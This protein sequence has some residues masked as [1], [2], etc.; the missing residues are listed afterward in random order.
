MHDSEATHLTITVTPLPDAAERTYRS[1]AQ[2]NA[3]QPG[4]ER[5]S[6]RAPQQAAALR[7]ESPVLG[8]RHSRFVAPFSGAALTLIMRVLNQ[9]Q[10]RENPRTC[11]SSQEQRQLAALGLWH[12]DGHIHPA[13]SQRIG[14][15]LYQALTADPPGAQALHT[16]RDYATAQGTPLALNLRLP[17]DSPQLAVLPW[18]LLCDEGAVPL[19]LSRGRVA[20]CTR[21]LDMA[22]A[23]PLPPAH[24]TPLRILALAPHADMPAHH[25]HTEQQARYAAW[26]PLLNSG[27]VC[28]EEVSPVTRAALVDRMQHHPLPDIIH[29]YGHGRYQQGEGALLLDAP[30]G[31]PCWTGASTLAALFGGVRMVA[32]FACQGATVTQPASLFSG[33]A[34]ALCAAGIPLVL[35]M[36]FMVRVRAAVR[37]SGVM[38]RALAAGWSVQRAVSLVR[39]ALYVEEPDR[40][41]WYVPVLYV[42]SHN[43]APVAL[44]A[45]HTGA[46]A[47]TTATP[48]AQ[49]SSQRISARHNSQVHGICMRGSTATDQQ[50]SAEHHSAIA[51]ARL[52]GSAATDQQH[53]AAEQHAEVSDVEMVGDGE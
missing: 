25:R 26:Q 19:L 31:A 13:A 52:R 27:H 51:R 20:P 24:T 33:V 15:M 32:L 5:T 36:Q 28:M 21:Y 4:E 40:S 37:A 2:G 39:Q 50:V 14:R 35:G 48:P 23:T 47:T 49:R 12:P 22:H 18:E 53:I 43:T 45:P 42:R 9:T 7:W 16:A 44:I 6:E 29:Y 1:D 3:Q 17:A 46:S 11:F 30:D 38:Y 10:T 34:P 8:V 41:S